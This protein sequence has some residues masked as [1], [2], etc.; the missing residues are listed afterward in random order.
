MRTLPVQ[1]PGRPDHRSAARYLLWLTRVQGWPVTAG[2]IMGVFWMVSQAFMP[3]VIG[4]AIDQGIAD[5]DPARLARW[6]AILL[7]LGL[8]QAVAGIM[9]HRFAVYNWLSAAYRT[10]QVTVR[11]ANQLG[12]ALP[13]RLGSGEVVSIGTSDIS[14]IGHAVDITAR[15]A[16]AIVAI[17]TVAVILLTSSLPLGLVV[18]L[19]VPVLMAVVS[20]LIRPLH[21]RQQE[22][23]DEQGA[24]TTRAADIVSG[25]RVLRGVGGEAVFAARYRTHS[26]QLR[27]AGVRVAR[28]ESY[29]E[30]A[31]VL[32][33]GTFVVLVTWLGA[34]FAADGRISAGQ[35]VA[36][37]GYAAFLNFPLRTLTEAVDKTTRAHVAARRVVRL[38]NLEPDL[39]DPQRPA[40]AP[41]TD[42]DLIDAESGA[43]IRPGRLTAI[44]AADPRDAAEIADR[45]GRYRDGVVTLSGVPLRELSRA[46]VRELIMVA[47]NDARL[48][49]GPLRS[50]LASG[51]PDGPPPTD[52]QLRAALDAASATDVVDGLDRGLDSFVSERGREFSGGQQQRLRLARALIADPPILVLVEP[53]SAV[54]AHTEARI[55]TRLGAARRGRTTVVTTSSPLMLDAADHVI[56]VEDGKVLIEG[57][58]RELLEWEPRYA[59]TVTRGEG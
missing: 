33:P 45:L 41:A 10:I 9:R 2:M 44:A 24:L 26:Q 21:H 13:K 39:A 42:G 32:L 36:F 34:R 53:T 27:Q 28:V 3:A 40:A 54:D 11:K 47:D 6:A 51:R 19:G 1:D 15:G 38:L 48:F 49:T 57:R 29:L 22:Y 56:Y 31:Q 52:E 7:V 25:L 17:V 12:A 50:E 14:H 37:Y 8:T 58:H 46:T 20:L 30:A 18:V 43:V 5:H 55:A 59:A 23:R 16:G 35:L 4:R